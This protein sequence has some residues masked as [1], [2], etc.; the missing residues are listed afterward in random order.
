[1]EGKQLQVLPSMPQHIVGIFFFGLEYD[2]HSF[3]YVAQFFIFKKMSED[4]FMVADW[5]MLSTLSLA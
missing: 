2:G 1:V 4:K 3:A 5:G